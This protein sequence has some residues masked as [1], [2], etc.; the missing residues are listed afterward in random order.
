MVSN[1][2]VERGVDERVVDEEY[3]EGRLRKINEPVG[4]VVQLTQVMKKLARCYG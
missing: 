4:V 3:W 2:D 1:S